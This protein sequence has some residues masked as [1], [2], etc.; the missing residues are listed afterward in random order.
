MSVN[1]ASNSFKSGASTTTAVG[2]GSSAL[3]CANAMT[4]PDDKGESLANSTRRA[5]S[6]ATSLLWAA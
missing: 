5:S 2:A 3:A 1:R 6:M 4:A